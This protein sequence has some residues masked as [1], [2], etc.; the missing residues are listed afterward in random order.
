MGKVIYV[1][2]MSLDGF[3]S[4]ANVRPE[5]GLG[6]GGERLHEWGFNSADPRNRE[7]VA[8]WASIGAIIVGRTTYD[9][10][11]PYWGADGPTG[12]ARVP[13]VIVSHSVPQDIPSG[14]VYTFGNGVEAAFETAQK[15]AGDKDISTTGANV[16]QQLLTRGLID[17]ISIHL[18][19]VLF[20][21]GT[22]LFEGLDSEHI[23]LETVEVIETAE[24]I[25]LRFRVVK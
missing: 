15:L 13:T 22:R 9:L 4:G 25:H 18:V 23:S 10:S 6:E 21:S 7:I 12:A 24:A 14:G 17:E 11:I 3:I 2:S 20:G 1:V 19:P 5:A 16:A 8:G